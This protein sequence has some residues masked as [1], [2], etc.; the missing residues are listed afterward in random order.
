M[1]GLSF[2]STIDFTGLERSVILAS[3]EGITLAGELVLEES[4]R[5]VPIEEGDL[6]R[7]GAVRRQSTAAGKTAVAISFNTPYAARQHE[8][9][10][11]NHKDGRQA[12][13][14]EQPLNANG[15][16][17]IALIAE[18]CRRAMQ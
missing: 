3:R 15:D 18:T 5:L 10:T 9:T 11:W 2:T 16:R 4:R 8:E 14:L 17:V 13:Y 7:S 1:A 6:M 12:K